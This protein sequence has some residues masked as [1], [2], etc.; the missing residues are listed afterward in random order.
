[1]ANE[2]TS[3]RA[4]KRNSAQFWA[5]D[6]NRA[7]IAAEIRPVRFGQF[8]R[9]SLVEQITRSGRSIPFPGRDALEFEGKEESLIKCTNG[10]AASGQEMDVGRDASRSV[11]V[12]RALVAA[13]FRA[14]SVSRPAGR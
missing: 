12:C 3:E 13:L 4:N 10:R 11:I 8:W 1:M 5:A 14:H 9:A 2:R 7:P 6:G